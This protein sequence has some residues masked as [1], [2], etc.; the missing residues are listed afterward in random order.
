MKHLITIISIVFILSSI[1][2]ASEP[3]SVVYSFGKIEFLSSGRTEWEFLKKDTQ[4]S[5]N[6][7]IRMPPISLLR[8]KDEDGNFLPLF[9]G[10]YELSVA[11]LFKLGK[12]RLKEQQGKQIGSSFNN[13]PAVDILPTGDRVDTVLN[14]AKDKKEKTQFSNTDLKT[15]ERLLENI[16]KKVKESGKRIVIDSNFTEDG[17][18][19]K[20]LSYARSLF[21]GLNKLVEDNI[22]EENYR[23]LDNKLKKVVLYSQLLKTLEIPFDLQINEDFELII[24]LDTG[25]IKDK[26]KLITVNHNLVRSH[27]GTLWIGINMEQTDNFTLAWYKGSQF[28]WDE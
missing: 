11:E 14:S 7:I 18:P 27:N 26:I 13:R 15:I 24:V 4:L 2:I 12:N 17:Y 8:L 6:D 23:N 1:S 22:L 9:T 21:M 25:I 10:S 28:K 16:S 3:A 20:N 19:N 5:L